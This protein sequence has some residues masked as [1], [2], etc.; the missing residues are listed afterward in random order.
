MGQQGRVAEQQGEGCRAAVAGPAGR[1]VAGGWGWAGLGRGLVH[2]CQ[3]RVAA[4]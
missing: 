3:S 4:D 1:S 2:W